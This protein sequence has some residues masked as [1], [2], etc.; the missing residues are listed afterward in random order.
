MSE[1]ITGQITILI[2]GYLDL[3]IFSN[4]ADGSL[5]NIVMSEQI[6]G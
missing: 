2:K 6:T 4:R 3:I 1:Q 5:F